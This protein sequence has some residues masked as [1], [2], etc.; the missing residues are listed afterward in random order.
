VIADALSKLVTGDITPI[1]AAGKRTKSSR[2]Q[3]SAS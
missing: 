3:R 1:E 2:Q